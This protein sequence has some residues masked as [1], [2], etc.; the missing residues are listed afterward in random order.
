MMPFLPQLQ[1]ALVAHEHEDHNN[2]EPHSCSSGMISSLFSIVSEQANHLE[3]LNQKVE[4]M[5]ER[6]RALQ[7]KV[8]ELEAENEGIKGERKK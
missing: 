8:L 4:E 6:N 5:V 3:I 1:P 7:R 2:C